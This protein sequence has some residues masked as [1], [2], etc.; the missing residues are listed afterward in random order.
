MISHTAVRS[1]QLTQLI[2]A[3]LLYV[4]I[5][6]GLLRSYLIYLQPIMEP[7]AKIVNKQTISVYKR[8]LVV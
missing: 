5:I 1:C 3:T 4:R 6:D 2:P 8:H 7:F